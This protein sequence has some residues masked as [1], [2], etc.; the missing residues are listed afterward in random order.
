MSSNVNDRTYHTTATASPPVPSPDGLL[1]FPI[2]WPRDSEASPK[3]TTRSKR[4]QVK[5][6]CTLCQKSCKKCDEA[7]PCLRCV[8]YGV[9]ERCVNSQRKERKKGTKRGPYRKR[10]VRDQDDLAGLP[11]SPDEP[12]MPPPPP[13]PCHFPTAPPVQPV[14]YTHPSL[15]PKPGEQAPSHSI[16]C[17]V[18]VPAQVDMGVPYI[19]TWGWGYHAYPPHYQYP[20]KGYNDH[21]GVVPTQSHMNY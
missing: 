3:P 16:V 6:A 21:L 13:P 8:R 9:P 1:M 2:D 11:R 19:A 20:Y 5:N 14:F 15:Y 17:P 18:S 4:R 7:R 10:D 12:Q